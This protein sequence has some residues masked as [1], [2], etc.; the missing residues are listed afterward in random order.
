MK[1]M[2]AFKPTFT[3]DLHE[4]LNF[5]KPSGYLSSKNVPSLASPTFKTDFFYML[6]A[7]IIACLK[8]R[9]PRQL[10]RPGFEN[11]DEDLN[12]LVLDLAGDGEV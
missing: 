8:S 9:S 7:Q 3:C 11:L 10:S 1:N 12:W 4:C 5:R 6:E 2:F